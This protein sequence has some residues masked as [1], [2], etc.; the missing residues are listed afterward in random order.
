MQLTKRIRA[1]INEFDSDVLCTLDAC[2]FLS[3]SCIEKETAMRKIS[4]IQFVFLSN[5]CT[6]LISICYVN[7]SIEIPTEPV[8]VNTHRI[9][10]VLPVDAYFG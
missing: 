7:L 2:Q 3:C 4:S 9:L 1:P 10:F 6:Q 8:L 5:Y